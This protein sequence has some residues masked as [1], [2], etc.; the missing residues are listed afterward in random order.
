VFGAAPEHGPIEGLPRPDLEVDQQ[1]ERE[2][3][4][5]EDQNAFSIHGRRFEGDGL[6]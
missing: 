2:Q 4:N 5:A 6:Q 1:T 3:N